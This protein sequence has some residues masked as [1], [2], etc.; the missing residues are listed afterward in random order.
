MSDLLKGLP[1]DVILKGNALASA[2]GFLFVATAPV[3]DDKRVLRA[4]LSAFWV[5]LGGYYGIRD[6]VG[7]LAS[8]THRLATFFPVSDFTYPPVFWLPLVI[9][10]DLPIMAL[11]YAFAVHELRVVKRSTALVVLTVAYGVAWSVAFVTN[12]SAVSSIYTFAVFF[13]LSWHFRLVKIAMAMVW[14][15]YAVLHLPL[16]LATTVENNWTTSVFLLL[17]AGK[18]ALITAMYDVLGVKP[19]T[20]T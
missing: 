19:K 13:Y 14:L 11:A 20:A 1:L 4:W 12:N 17:I 2:I 8:S 9:L 10:A 5:L 7:V 15:S 18:L 3:D 16:R 6:V